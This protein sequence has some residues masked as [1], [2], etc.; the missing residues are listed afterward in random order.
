MA[1]GRV[2]G[3]TVVRGRHCR[4]RAAS[5]GGGRV[6]Y[7]ARGYKQARQTRKPTAQ[8]EPA[9]FWLVPSISEG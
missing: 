1:T 3:R 9:R 8:M 7:E 5:R 2:D 4:R 6:A